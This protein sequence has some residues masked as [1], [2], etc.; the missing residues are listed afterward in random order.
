MSEFKAVN[1]GQ[2]YNQ[3]MENVVVTGTVFLL[4]TSP[5]FC[6]LLLAY[7][8]IFTKLWWLAL[9]YLIWMKYDSKTPGR[10]GRPLKVWRKLAFWNH[11]KNYFPIKLIKTAEI[12]ADKNYIFA[13]HP[14][15]LMS[16]SCFGCLTNDSCKIDK[17]FPGLNLHFVT[18]PV[19]FCIPFRRELLLWLGAIDHSK[20]SVCHVLDKTQEK[21]QVAVIVI[22]GADEAS[23]CDDPNIKVVLRERKGFVKIALRSGASLVPVISFGENQLYDQVKAEPGSL[24]MKFQDKVREKFGFIPIAFY[25]RSLFD[26]IPLYLP[27]RRPLFTVIGEPIEVTHSENP[28]SEEIDHVHEQYVESLKRLCEKYKKQCGANHVKLEIV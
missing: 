9:L 7:T 13:C 18:L 3:F 11:F 12:S 2:L 16:L 24:L 4:I 1:F 8:L 26:Y 23:F 14:H 10:C 21:G 20:K 15:G 6:M 5:P 22:G 28:S 27:Y 17:L 19:Q 25:G